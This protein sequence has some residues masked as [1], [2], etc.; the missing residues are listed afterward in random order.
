MS[1]TAGGQAGAG[2]ERP[3]AFVLGGAR[4]V[5]RAIV[6]ALARA[7]CDVDFSF[8]SSEED[9]LA[10]TEQA[11]AHGVACRA[12]R[13]GLND[14]AAVW[15]GADQI[16]SVTGRWDVVVVCASSYTPTPFEKLTPEQ[17]TGAFAV[18]AAAGALVAQNFLPGLRR[19]ILPGGG[20]VVTMCDI[21]AMGQTGR[22]RKG[23]LAY[24]MS[25]AALL[26][27]TLVLARELAPEVRV[28]G[29]APGVVAWPEKGSEADA[30]EQAKYLS[31]V[32]L[33]RAGTP[34]EAAEAVR[35]LAMDATYCTGQIVRLDGGRSLT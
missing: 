2:A 3:R 4:R 26:E 7:G 22:T 8:N 5:G 34:E 25:K 30:A 13:L 15:A 33:G 32:P 18:N 24:S 20:C 35:W 12:W 17:L 19:S 6:L 11:R 9:A 27:M 21:H 1:G 14:P 28:N 31:R 10:T 16:A 29:V 23:Y